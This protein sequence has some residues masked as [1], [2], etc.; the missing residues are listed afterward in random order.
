MTEEQK[1]HIAMMNSY[2]YLVGEVEIDD[3]L[4]SDISFFA[5]IPEQD[6]TTDVLE[7]M[8]YYFQSHEM[9]EHCAKLKKFF[10]ENF[11]EDG[12]PRNNL[13]DCPLPDVIEYSFKTKCNRCNKR[14]TR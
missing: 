4:N 7:F 5:H 14:I 1:V 3:I 8:I 11:Y 9:F 12:T 10:D 2:R 6:T 13:C